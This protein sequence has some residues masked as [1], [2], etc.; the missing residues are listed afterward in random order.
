MT[1]LKQIQTYLG[2][3]ASYYLEH[4]SKTVGKERLHLPNPDF[5][6]REFG[7]SNRSA[8]VLRSLQSLYGHGRLAG[9]ASST[10]RALRSRRIPSTSIRRTS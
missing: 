8:Q 9:R 6:S 7:S 4:Q 2:E 5:V 3:K 10:R 1:Q